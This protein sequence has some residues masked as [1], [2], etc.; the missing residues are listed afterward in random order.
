ARLPGNIGD[1]LDTF[2]NSKPSIDVNRHVLRR[3]GGE[4]QPSTGGR[5]SRSSSMMNASRT[6]EVHHADA[7]N[8]HPPPAPPTSGAAE[9]EAARYQMTRTQQEKSKNAPLSI[10]EQFLAANNLPMMQS[11]YKSFRAHSVD[12]MSEQASRGRHGGRQRRGGESNYSG[13]HAEEDGAFSEVGSSSSRVLHQDAD[14]RMNYMHDNSGAAL[15]PR[16]AD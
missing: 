1:S 10:H 16:D 13:D 4:L 8:Q 3:K 14:R 12:K 7:H 6:S 9:Q 15:L 11:N 2:M 5:G